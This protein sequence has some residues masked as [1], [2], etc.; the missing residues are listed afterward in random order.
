MF[1][2]ERLYSSLKGSRGSTGLTDS[3]TRGYETAV[4]DN[5]EFLH[6]GGQEDTG[7]GHQEGVNALERVPDIKPLEVD[8]SGGHDLLLH[9]QLFA[10]RLNHCN[11]H[12]DQFGSDYGSAFAGHRPH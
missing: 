10:Q 6:F 3:L 4:R 9:F 12:L 7:G 11:E 1:F 2:T 5:T 8:D